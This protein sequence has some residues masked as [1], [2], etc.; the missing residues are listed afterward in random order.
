MRG[1]GPKDMEICEDE[2]E[3]L[4]AKVIL[5]VTSVAEKCS[6]SF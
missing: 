2:E 6:S 3:E 5:T 1:F 4:K